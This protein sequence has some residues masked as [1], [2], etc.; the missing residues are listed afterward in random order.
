MHTYCSCYVC[1]ADFG[2]TCTPVSNS[3]IYQ[4][5]PPT[6]PTAVLSKHHCRKCGNGVCDRC[7]KTFMPVPSRGWDN[8]VRVCDK[9]VENG[10]GG[11]VG[12]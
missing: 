5:G 1:E 12:M 8:P 7:S 6:A 4:T 9:C 2:V 11:V 3:T 10:R